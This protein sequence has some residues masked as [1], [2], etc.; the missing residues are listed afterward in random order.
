M[1]MQELKKQTKPE[2][3]WPGRSMYHQSEYNENDDTLQEEVYPGS[4]TY[5]NAQGVP[6]RPF[7]SGSERSSM[8]MHGETET[9]PPVISEAGI[10]DKPAS[11]EN[12]F[13]GTYRKDLPRMPI[14]DFDDDDDWPE[15]EDSDQVGCSRAVVSLGIDE[16]ISFSDLEDDLDISM[17][18]GP[19]SVSVGQERTSS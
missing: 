13:T 11:G 12:A 5:F 1:W 3:D 4:P 19:K 9:L 16:D 10:V 17:P 18:I 8:Q 6:F 14:E 7:S 2:F 15:E